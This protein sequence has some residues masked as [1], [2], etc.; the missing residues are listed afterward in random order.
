[1]NED[2]KSN[3]KPRGYR[4]GAALS[5]SPINNLAQGLWQFAYKFDVYAPLAVMF[6]IGIV[7][8]SYTHLDVYKRQVKEVVMGDGAACTLAEA[9]GVER[10][11]LRVAVGE[12]C[13]HRDFLLYLRGDSVG[14]A[15]QEEAVFAERFA[16]IRYVEEGRVVAGLLGLEEF[17]GLSED[18]VGVEPVSYTHLDV[19][20]RQITARPTRSA[21]PSHSK[22]SC[23]HASRRISANARS[24]KS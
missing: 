20:K 14:N 3:N 8:V 24:R 11:A 21:T 12:P 17:D 1:M 22:D 6:I 2:V 23:R 15:V 10:E 19:Y 16:M 5:S 4:H 7:A 9:L 13:H 18:M